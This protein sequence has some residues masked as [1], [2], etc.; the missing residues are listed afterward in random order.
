MHSDGGQFSLIGGDWE[1]PHAGATNLSPRAWRAWHF[2]ADASGYYNVWIEYRSSA[3]IDL[4][5]YAGSEPLATITTNTGGSDTTS[6]VYP[7]YSTDGLKSIRVEN[8]G[9]A[10][11]E[12]VTIHVEYDPA[13][14]DPFVTSIRRADANPTN[15][16]T[17]DFTVTFS[18]SVTGV[19]L[20]DFSL[21]TSGVS[22]ATLGGVAGSGSVYTLTVNTGSGNGA[23]R[24]DLLDNDSILD[25]ALNPLGGAGAGNG[26]FTSGETY[27][28]VRFTLTLRSTGANDGWVLESSE[29]SG[30]GGTMDAAATTFRLG[31]DTA[32]KQYRSILSFNT[33]NLPDTAVITKVTLKIRQSGLP[34]GT[35]PF[36]THG[37]LKVDIRKPYFGT[38]ANLVASDFQAGANKSAIGTFSS[39]P[40]SSWF[41][42]LLSNTAFPYINLTGTTQFRLRFA[43][44]DNDDMSADYMRFISGNHATVSARPTLV[45]E[46]YVP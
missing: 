7:F 42:A 36:T 26:N 16:A 9:N 6:A 23:I 37:G 35:N 40:I 31:D 1:S 17:V 14:T 44:E 13:L 33:I 22:G 4:R 30:K 5:L 2:D 25:A 24:L 11:F 39:T 15:A 8:L 28:V 34:V 43:K 32:D 45:I 38:S 29:T 46:Y 27:T 21:T 20:D 41:S 18:E 19:D 12:L 10:N 3:A